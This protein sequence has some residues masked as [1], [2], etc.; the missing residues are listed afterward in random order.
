MS[1]LPQSPKILYS[2]NVLIAAE[3]QPMYTVKR[4]TNQKNIKVL[5]L[6]IQIM[7]LRII[8]QMEAVAIVVTY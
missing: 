1:A 5:H 7:S 6:N 8:T 3:S 2:T 4:A